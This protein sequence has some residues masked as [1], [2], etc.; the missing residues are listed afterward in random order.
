MYFLPEK[1]IKSLETL[2]IGLAFE[3]NPKVQLFTFQSLHINQDIDNTYLETHLAKMVAKSF[4]VFNSVL[5]DKDNVNSILFEWDFL[6]LLLSITAFDKNFVALDTAYFSCSFNFFP[7]I[8]NTW[9]FEENHFVYLDKIM[10]NLLQK[11]FEIDTIY[12][13]CLSF[14]NNGIKILYTCDEFFSEFPEST[15]ITQLF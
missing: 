15:K 3:Y 9:E 2:N 11:V 1:I 5:H 10:P 6:S 8:I 4:L 7:E 12:E 13:A 14:A